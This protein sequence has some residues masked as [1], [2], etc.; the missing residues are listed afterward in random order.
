LSLSE[1]VVLPGFLSGAAIR[2]ALNS[3]DAFVLP[4]RQDTYAAVVH[5]AACLGLPLLVSKHAG[6][7]EAL[8]QSGKNGFVIDPEDAAEFANRMADLMQDT[9]REPM[10]AVSRDIGVAH[11]AHLRG[12]ALW[13]WMRD[14]SFA[15]A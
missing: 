11:S 15:T 2:D 7:A 9:L 3:A 5:E 1:Q 12:G 13:Q 10:R 4:T 14:Q 8:V 6:A